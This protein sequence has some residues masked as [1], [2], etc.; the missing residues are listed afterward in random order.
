[1]F[2]GTR[3]NVDQ[4]ISL[5]NRI[6]IMFDDDKRIAEIPQMMQCPDQTLVITLMQSDGRFIQHIHHADQTGADLRGKTDTLRFAA[7][8]RGRGTRQRQII[9]TDIVQEAKTRL[10][11]LEH[12]ARDQRRGA[13][14]LQ[15]THPFQFPH[16]TSKMDLPS[17]VTASTSGLSLRPLHSWHGTSRM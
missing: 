15:A 16:H 4:P 14:E 10:D 6:L 13:G 5:T 12:L 3:S 7:G 9:K 11:L 8:Q 17:T 1:M 2:A